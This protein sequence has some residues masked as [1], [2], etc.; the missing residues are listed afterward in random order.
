MQDGP[1]YQRIPLE[2]EMDQM[3][4][5]PGCVRLGLPSGQVRLQLQSENALRLVKFHHY[6]TDVVFVWQLS[7]CKAPEL[8]IPCLGASHHIG[9]F[10]IW[11][12]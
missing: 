10:Y 2:K 9:T 8:Y 6:P 5:K 7:V 1:I 3:G 12:A 11:R 4:C